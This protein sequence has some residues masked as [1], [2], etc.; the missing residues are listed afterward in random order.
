MRM[1]KR[2]D[3]REA[4]ASRTVRTAMVA[5]ALAA[6][7]GWACALLMPHAWRAYLVMPRSLEIAVALMLVAGG[8]ATAIAA[9]RG[10]ELLGE[11][12]DR[13]K[14]TIPPGIA[15]M[16]LL[17]IAGV[18]AVV[19]GDKPIEAALLPVV[20]FV[21]GWFV[22]RSARLA[23]S[24]CTPSG[25]GA[26]RAM[27]VVG[28][29]WGFE[30]A[31]HLM[32][33]ARGS[34][35][36]RSM[37]WGIAYLVL[38]V[39]SAMRARRFA[40]EDFDSMQA[41]RAFPRP[42]APAALRM[43][44]IEVSFGSHRILHHATLSTNPGEI[45]ALV[46]ANGS[47]KS[48]LLK[49]AG[50]VVL[51]HRGRVMLGDDD[52]TLLWPEERALMG[53]M[54][55][56]GA[57]PIFPDLSVGQNLMVAAG[58]GSRSAFHQL[59]AAVLDVVPALAQ[60][61]NDKAGVLSGGEQRLLAVAQLLYRKPRVLLVDELSA[62]LD[63]QAR[64]AVLDLLRLFAQHGTSVVIVDHDLGALLPRCDRAALLRDGG[65]RMFEDPHALLS[66]HADLLPATFLSGAI[67]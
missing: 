29:A 34:G 66:F 26:G 30:I 57:R 27:I 17:L 20:P 22:G 31:V 1:G 39:A 56:S 19:A 28:G 6:G 4:A 60:R 51:S 65:I 35:I 49:V 18:Y 62:G 38:A 32:L 16:L 15:P 63:D 61:Q 14:R 43:D 8:A 9:S 42:P 21:S 40:G 50:G 48:T 67:R 10:M 2:A 45:V 47:G 46:G 52:V 24:V 5:S 12:A 36:I 55:V 13:T 53:L 33:V 64:A 44:G 59:T 25:G 23:A 58:P 3:R 11:A 41:R 37:V 7:P 54:F